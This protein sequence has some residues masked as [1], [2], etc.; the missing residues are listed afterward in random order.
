MLHAIGL[1]FE[2]TIGDRAELLAL[3]EREVA[4]FGNPART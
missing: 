3:I 1:E 4:P 2:P